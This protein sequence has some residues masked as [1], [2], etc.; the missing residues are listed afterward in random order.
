MKMDDEKKRTVKVT[1]YPDPATWR[2]LRVHA[3]QNGTSANAIVTKL[4]EDFMKRAA[5]KGGTR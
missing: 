5:K 3:I 2:A 1:I 4:V